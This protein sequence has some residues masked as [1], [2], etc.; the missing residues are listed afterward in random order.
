VPAPCYFASN[1]TAE[2]SVSGCTDWR[3][4]LPATKSWLPSL[5][6]WLASPGPCCPAAKVS[7]SAA[8]A[9]GSLMAVEKMLRLESPERFPLSHRHDDE[10]RQCVLRDRGIYKDRRVRIIIKWP[11]SDSPLGGRIHLR[12]CLEA[13][14]ITIPTLCA[15]NLS[16]EGS[17]CSPSTDLALI[18]PCCFY[19]VFEMDCEPFSKIEPRPQRLHCH[20]G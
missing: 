17:N 9:S 10:T 7:T 16:R 8:A 13:E 5:T 14:E 6:N 18:Y 11:E 1:T 12:Q 3:N 19:V 15:G 4:V 2:D 20:C